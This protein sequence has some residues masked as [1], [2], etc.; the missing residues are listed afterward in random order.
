MADISGQLALWYSS[1]WYQYLKIES[2]SQA[3]FF[4]KSTRPGLERKGSSTASI[5][6]L[7]YSY[8]PTSENKKQ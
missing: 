1:F 6:V 3:D 8:F 7:C 2:Q 5:L 4:D